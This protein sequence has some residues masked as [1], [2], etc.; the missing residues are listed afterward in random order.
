MTYKNKKVN[1]IDDINA[2][3]ISVS[4]EEPY[5]TK[6]SFQYFIRYNDNDVIIPLCIKLPQMSGNVSKFE[7]NTTILFKISNKQFLKKY[8]QSNMEK[9]WKIIENKIWQWTCSWWW[10]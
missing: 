10:W 7:D 3:K 1:K 6:K 8:N 9:S 5:G 2:N 4:K